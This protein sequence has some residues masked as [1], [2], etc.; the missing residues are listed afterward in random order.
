VEKIS[1]S[2]GKG[3]YIWFSAAWIYD[4]STQ[5]LFALKGDCHTRCFGAICGMYGLAINK[6]M[7]LF[8]FCSGAP[9]FFLQL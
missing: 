6:N 1:S 5:V 3:E 2:E 4:K 9:T 8:W 7:Y